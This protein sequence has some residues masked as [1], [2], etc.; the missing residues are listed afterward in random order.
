MSVV[1]EALEMVDTLGKLPTSPETFMSALDAIFQ[2]VS[3]IL[4][5]DGQAG[6]HQKVNEVMGKEV[7][8]E[9]DE[10]RLQPLVNF[11]VQIKYAKAEEPLDTLIKQQGGGYD[12][13]SLYASGIDYIKKLDEK[14]KDLSTKY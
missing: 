3:V 2:V 1:K 11:L 12:L 4:R 14:V 9:H 7:L 8:S 6:W 13:D 10:N 5:T